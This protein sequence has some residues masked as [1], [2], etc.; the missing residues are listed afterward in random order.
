M[1]F[2]NSSVKTGPKPPQVVEA[3]KVMQ[4]QF[5]KWDPSIKGQI[6][7]EESASEQLRVIEALDAARSGTVIRSK[8]Y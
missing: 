3:L 7:V 6:S 2:A 8:D 1:V 4:A 5:Q